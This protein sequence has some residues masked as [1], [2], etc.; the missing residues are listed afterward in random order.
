MQVADIKALNEEFLEMKRG[1]SEINE[2]LSLMASELKDAV[3]QP[4]FRT[5]ERYVDLWA[6]MKFV[7][8]EELE[9]ILKSINK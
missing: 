2:N 5:V 8:R 3:K 9:R 6:P 4:E 7:T 1:M